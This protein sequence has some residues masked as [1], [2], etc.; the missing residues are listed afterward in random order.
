MTNRHPIGTL[1]VPGL[2]YEYTESI[3]SLP[4]VIFKDEQ[5]TRRRKDKM[6]NLFI[7]IDCRMISLNLL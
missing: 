6:S 4:M 5:N 1:D 3:S 2:L 7:Q